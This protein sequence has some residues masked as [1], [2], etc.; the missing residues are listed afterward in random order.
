MPV[1]QFDAEGLHRAILNL[2]TNA[3]DALN[4][5]EGAEVTIQTQFDPAA[6]RILVEVADNGPG[7]DPAELPRIFNAFESTK[8]GGGTGLGLAVTQ[9][10]LREHG[11]E[12]TVDTRPGQGCR[13]RL[14]WPMIEEEPEAA[15][16]QTLVAGP[17]DY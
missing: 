13:F 11:G 5:Q 12:V 1:S 16:R 10:I 17:E 6:D 3:F 4:G 2:V 15:V 14:S 9:K 7:I 8:G